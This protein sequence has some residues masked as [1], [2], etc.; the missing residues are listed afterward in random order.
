MAVEEMRSAD[1][2]SNPDGDDSDGIDKFGLSNINDLKRNAEEREAEAAATANATKAKEKTDS[3]YEDDPDQQDDEEEQR[4][5][6]DMGLDNEEDQLQ[7]TEDQM[8]DIAQNIFEM[9]AQ[10]LHQKN[11]TVRNTF[12]GDDMI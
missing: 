4:D 2:E 1:E 6:V 12:G 8:L 10:C 11:L 3:D 9:I 5:Q 7:I